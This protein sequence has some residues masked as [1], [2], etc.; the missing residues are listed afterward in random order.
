MTLTASCAAR[1]RRQAFSLIEAAIVLA[2][3]GLV[4]GGIWVAAETLQRNRQRTQ[5]LQDLLLVS[6]NVRQLFKGTADSLASNTSLTSAL[7]RA[8]AV[9]KDWTYD[10]TR[11]VRADGATLSVF[12]YTNR[13][14]ISLI[15][16]DSSLCIWIGK[17]VTELNLAAAYNVEVFNPVGGN[18]GANA[19]YRAS[20]QFPVSDS[21]LQSLCTT[22]LEVAFKFD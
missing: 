2:I 14:S 10:G 21:T 3:I 13:F 18:A 4:I 17:R 20:G 11:L 19:Q 8:G 1:L 9:P 22:Y 16:N 15:S 12:T 6:Q 5:T 7:Y